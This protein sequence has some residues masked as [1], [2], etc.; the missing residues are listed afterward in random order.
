MLDAAQTP[1][2]RASIIRVHTIRI[3]G[4]YILAVQKV[5]GSS[6]LPR[7]GQL[8][9]FVVDG[10]DVS[11]VGTYAQHAFRSYRSV[12]PVERVLTWRSSGF[13]LSPGH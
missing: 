11:I 6:D 3:C 4:E 7:E 5:T 1:P 10:Y 9:E 13:D 2:A 8:I 12:Y